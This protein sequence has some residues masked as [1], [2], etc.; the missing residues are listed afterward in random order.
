VCGLLGAF[1]GAAPLTPESLRR[2]DLER[3]HHRG[4]DSDG[5]YRDAHAALGF[6]R[7]AIIDQAGGD[8]PLF[9]TAG[10]TVLTI[11]G[12]IYNHR[13]LRASLSGRHH[14][15]TR[16]DAEV[17]VHRYAESGLDG[18]LD[19]VNGMFAFALYD[20]ARRRMVLGRDR[21]GQK[22][23]YW[24]F[25]DGTLR[26]SS[27]LKALLGDRR[28]AVDRQAL[29]DYLRFGYVPAPL[30]IFQGV[31]KLEAG[32]TLVCEGD[33][34]PVVQ[35]YWSLRYGP[36]NDA[37]PSKAEADEWR[38]ALTEGLSDA[39]R[40]RMES[41][42][43]MGFLLSGGVD[44]ASVLAMGAQANASPLRAFT[45]SFPGDAVDEA[46]PAAE[47]AARWKASHEVRPV[48]TDDCQDLGD[49]LYWVEEPLST[50][51]L[52][53]TARVFKEVAAAG[54]TTVLTGEG[55]DEI[56]AGY[57][58]FE[59]A[60]DWVDAG[61]RWP[62]QGSAL[63]R[64]LSLEEFC[65][66]SP[67][68]REALLGHGVDDSRFASLEQEVADLS[69]LSQMLHIEARLR[70][71]DR[72]NTRLDK[73]SMA[74]S[75]EARAPFMDY[76]LQQLCAG[77]PH[78]LRRGATTDKL[79]LR[80]S[81]GPMLPASV[82]QAKKAPFRAPA[83]WFVDPSMLDQELGDEAVDEA[84]M[85][86]VDRVREL[87]RGQGAPD[88]HRRQEELYSLFVLHAW[89]RSFVREPQ[90]SLAAAAR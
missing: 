30:T 18:L 79:L 46:G 11:N 26:W 10:R 58:K 15:R 84:G 34:A 12:E 3:L 68:D 37:S 82:L 87:R 48:S 49:A 61:G 20:P 16:S 75:V 64:Y 43:P 85:V 32:T 13:A 50:D 67:T 21:S 45:I 56:M 70:L 14:F 19:D 22:P 55:A 69:P 78:R 27:E 1:R 54:I 40:L 60:C 83:R 80:Q 63:D 25:T 35:R 36:D 8:Q 42:A 29:N 51:A 23:L 72:I 90:V 89:H 57:R 44:S 4:P 77:M 31:H 53:P 2:S 33:G 86:S 65:F 73:L 52:L 81:L 38:E 62:A 5:W 7:L 71:P 88:P 59:T 17:L 41:E 28:P 6:R 66:P 74:C 39:V 24:T 9:D 47:V 76:R